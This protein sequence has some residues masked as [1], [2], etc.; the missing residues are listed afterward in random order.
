MGDKSCAVV[1]FPQAQSGGDM[2]PAMVNPR[3][4]CTSD[5]GHRFDCAG[6]NMVNGRIRQRRLGIVRHSCNTHERL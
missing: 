5:T 3:L 6:G 4:M 2:T 1:T